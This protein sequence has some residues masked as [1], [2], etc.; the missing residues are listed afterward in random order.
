M[1]EELLN[2]GALKVAFTKRAAVFIPLAMKP[3]SLTVLSRNQ[4]FFELDFGWFTMFMG[5]KMT[6]KLLEGNK[7][8]WNN[9]SLTCDFQ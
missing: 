1:V 4:Y 8:L 6:R 3:K 2:L 5:G 9:K 7:S